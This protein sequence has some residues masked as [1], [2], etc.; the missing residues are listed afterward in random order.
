VNI[1]STPRLFLLIRA[2]VLI[3]RSSSL[4]SVYARIVFLSVGVLGVLN[5]ARIIMRPWGDPPPLRV[6]SSSTQVVL[7]LLPVVESQWR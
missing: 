7:A 3:G 2:L 5:M 4:N 6:S 1:R